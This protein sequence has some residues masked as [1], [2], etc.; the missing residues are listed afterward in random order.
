[1]P[2]LTDDFFQRLGRPWLGEAIFDAVP[3]CVYFVKD[4]QARYIA[5]NRTLVERCGCSGKEELIG[6]TA[7]EV[8]PLPLGE[9]F[10]QQD[11]EVLSSGKP[12]HG[13]LELHVYAGGSQDWCLTWKEPLLDEKGAVIGL[14][15]ISRDLPRQKESSQLEDISEVLREIDEHLDQ[16]LTVKSLAEQSGLSTF[17]LDQR[18]RSLFGMSTGQYIVRRRI[19]RACH[20]LERTNESLSA[21]ALECG[22][23]DQSAFTRQFRQSVGIPPG[24]YRESRRHD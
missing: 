22:Y 1:M 10:L 9:S 5:V 24:A 2:D 21:I 13:Q 14:A 16:A 6:R 3:D 12:V 7:A 8:L 17:Q 4:D 11:H 23:S 15:G 18:I 19:D 20:L